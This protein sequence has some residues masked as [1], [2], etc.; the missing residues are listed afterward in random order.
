MPFGDLLG[1]DGKMLSPEGL[2]AAFRSAGVDTNGK[3]LTSCGSG[4]TAS[5]I[6]LA[7]A[8]L[9]RDDAPL[10][11]GSWAEWGADADTPVATGPAD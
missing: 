6:S 7:L 3:L 4:V 5:V 9:G 10:Y 1:E 2:Q 8:Q 11:D